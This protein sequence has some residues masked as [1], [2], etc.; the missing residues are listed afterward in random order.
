[1]LGCA[2]ENTCKTDR[3]T[4]DAMA[5][6]ELEDHQ[7]DLIKGLMPRQVR[8]GKWN[9]HRTTLNGILWVL[10]SGAPWRDMPDRYGKYTSVHDRLCRWRS[11]GTFD[12]ILTA[13][14]VRL[15]KQGKIDWDLWLV[16]GSNVRAS[17]AAAGARKKGAEAASSSPTTTHWV[18]AAADGDAHST[19]L[20]TE[21][22]FPLPSTSRRGKRTNPPKSRQ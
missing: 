10:R 1:M 7:W 16:D 15:D 13:L 2:F 5:R 6:Y 22:A 17:R 19:W 12:R 11:N 4:E 8:G 3:V 14:R 20:L 18:A 21:T 9:D